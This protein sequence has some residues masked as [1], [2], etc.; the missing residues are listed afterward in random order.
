MNFGFGKLSIALCVGLS[1]QFPVASK[2]QAGSCC[3]C[4][5]CASNAISRAKSNSVVAFRNLHSS[6]FNLGSVFLQKSQDFS[7]AINA[8]SNNITT[9]VEV[10]TLVQK[11]MKD[12]L[13]QQQEIRSQQKLLFERKHD[14]D[15]MYSA[16]EATQSLLLAYATQ[17]EFTAYEY[18]QFLDHHN[19]LYTDLIKSSRESLVSSYVISEP[20]MEEVKGKLWGGEIN[21]ADEAL[22][23]VYLTQQ[24]LFAGDPEPYKKLFNKEYNEIEMNRDDAALESKRITWA[25]RIQPAVDFFALDQGL[26]SRPYEDSPSLMGWLDLNIGESLFSAEGLGKMY[27]QDSKSDLYEALAV[28][29]KKLNQVRFL[30]LKTNQI[31]E[32]IYSANFGIVTNAEAGTLR[33][34]VNKDDFETENTSGGNDGR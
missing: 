11:Q 16:D 4:E 25:N 27:A 2:V 23:L 13:N 6:I 29:T 17:E 28:E 5:R 10:D 8:S 24:I 33:Y 32:R 31:K 20:K 9:Q 19:E 22:D 30:N 15:Q 21:D 3:G 26:R 1:I 14:L 34:L 12:A 18:S 7:Q